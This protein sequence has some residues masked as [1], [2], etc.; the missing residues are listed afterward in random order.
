MTGPPARSNA[1]TLDVLAGQCKIACAAAQRLHGGEAGEPA[2]G[3]R[4]GL[5]G[6]ADFAVEQVGE[7]HGLRVQQPSSRSHGV[8]LLVAV[9]VDEILRDDALPGRDGPVLRGVEAVHPGDH[10]HMV[11]GRVL[12]LDPGRRR[13]SEFT[14]PAG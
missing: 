7:A 13:D 14:R 5:V 9:S 8:G 2:R 10:D 3:R 6:P 12:G 4:G 1:K 11:A